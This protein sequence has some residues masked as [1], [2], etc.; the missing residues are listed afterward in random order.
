MSSSTYSSGIAA[1]MS[2]GSSVRLTAGEGKQSDKNEKKNREYKSGKAIIPA[3]AG[4]L[5]SQSKTGIW[6]THSA[7]YKKTKKLSKN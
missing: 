4:A 1:T 5:M 3:S 2:G 7:S 6:Y